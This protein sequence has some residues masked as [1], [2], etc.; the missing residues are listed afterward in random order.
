[1]RF[2]VRALSPACT[3]RSD[4]PPCASPAALNYG[5]RN[6]IDNPYDSTTVAAGLRA[7][8]GGYYVSNLTTALLG[9]VSKNLGVRAR[10]RVRRR[11]SGSD[12]SPSSSAPTP[13]RSSYASRP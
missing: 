1:M 8:N 11:V 5:L 9:D 13:L 7:V 10:L 3:L 4:A 12:L 6:A 2:R